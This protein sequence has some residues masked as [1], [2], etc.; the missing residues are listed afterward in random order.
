MP[1][2][3]HVPLD[4]TFRSLETR[5]QPVWNALI[6][7]QKNPPLWE[8]ELPD[9]LDDHILVL[10][11]QDFVNVRDGQVVE[12]KKIE[13]R[14]RGQYDRVWVTYWNHGV[15]EI[16]KGPLTTIEFSTHNYG[17]VTE[18]AEI[19]DDWKWIWDHPKTQAWQCLNGRLCSHRIRA[20]DILRHWPN[21]TL[22][23]G[24]EIPLNESEFSNYPLY[25]YNNLTNWMNLLPVY[26]RCAVNIITETLYDDPPGIITEKSL[27]AFA[28]RQIPIVIGHRGI[29]RHCRELGF[30][31]FDDL[32]DTSYDNLPDDVRVEE[33]I[34]RNR[35]LIQG[36]INLAPYQDRL[37]K[38]SDFVLTTFPNQR[39]AHLQQRC[40]ELLSF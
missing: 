20:C 29:V 27:M 3:Y 7:P 17:T 37:A 13:Q 40:R 2:L 6:I 22:S 33:A 19:V 10:N 34:L 16:Y 35:D 28:A 26:S 38:Q 14:Y 9:I 24:M 1:I 4:Q 11:C 15:E 31:M 23:L 30:D 39:L 18:L 21:G 32:V 12:F 36:K 8:L 5:I 25:N